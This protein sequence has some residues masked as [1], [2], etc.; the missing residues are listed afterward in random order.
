[1][2]DIMKSFASPVPAKVKQQVIM[3]VYQ[4]VKSF[5]SKKDSNAK[6]PRYLDSKTGRAN[7]IITNQAISKHKFN[8]E[9]KISFNFQNETFKYD[10]TNLKRKL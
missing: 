1:M 7:I 3:Q 6:L 8:K 2:F 10:I 5:Y 4:T 9:N